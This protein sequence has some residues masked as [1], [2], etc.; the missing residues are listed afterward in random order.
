MLVE[1][2]L[3]GDLEDDD[4]RIGMARL[5]AARQLIDATAIEAGI[6]LFPQQNKGLPLRPG[7]GRRQVETQ[8]RKHIERLALVRRCLQRL[9]DGK[10]MRMGE[11][12]RQAH[13]RGMRQSIVE[14]SKKPVSS[15]RNNPS[16]PSRSATLSYRGVSTGFPAA[17]PS[18]ILEDIW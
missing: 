1:R 9:E 2:R 7:A 5:E 11:L 6:E 8:L 13:P 10:A 12:T 3:M 17:S 4:P 18:P 16:T 15:N 14:R